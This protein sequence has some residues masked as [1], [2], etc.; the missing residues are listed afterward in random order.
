MKNSE[1][2]KEKEFD[3]V[4]FFR[5]V[6]EKIASETKGMTFAEFKQYISNRKLK[7]SR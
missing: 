7:A 2:V 4:K 1:Q 6:K 3:T 5:A